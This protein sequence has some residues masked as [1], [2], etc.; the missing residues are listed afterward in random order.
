M[1]A[2]DEV[3]FK[4]NAAVHAVQKYKN[5]DTIIDGYAIPSKKMAIGLAA[6]EDYAKEFHAIIDEMEFVD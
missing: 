3:T 1:L 6:K 4:N 2:L 5:K